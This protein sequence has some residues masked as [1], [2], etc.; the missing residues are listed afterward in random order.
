MA[1]IVADRRTA[2]RYFQRVSAVADNNRVSS[3]IQ[4]CLRW[5]SVHADRPIN[6]RRRVVVEKRI[7]HVYL[8]GNRLY[9]DRGAIAI[10]IVCASDHIRHLHHHIHV[11]D[12]LTAVVAQVL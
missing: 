11:H 5:R 6:F 4:G 3:G 9:V 7:A 8:L 1:A 2:H 12:L 10:V